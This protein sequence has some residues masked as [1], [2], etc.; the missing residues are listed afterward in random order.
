MSRSLSHHPMQLS[1]TV[2]VIVWSLL[3]APSFTFA[4][5]PDHP[6]I[7][8]NLLGDEVYGDFVLGP[9]KLEVTI[10]PGETKVVDITVSNRMGTPRMF[11][12]TAEDAVGSQDPTQTVVLL[13]ED[14][15]PYSMKDYVSVPTARFTLGHNERVRV[16]V[17][18]S[19]P[20]DAEPGGRY[21]SL[22][23][24]TVSQEAN[25]GVDAG[26]SP[27][28]AIVA[29]IG[30]LF[31]ITVPGETKKEGSLIQFGVVPERAIHQEGPL[32]F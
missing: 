32:T 7:I 26:T 14:R 2:L 1:F 19:I 15:G 20:Q 21:G 8:E 28:S 10:N 18:I 17:T 16:P 29:R 25:T 3:F 6:Y 22:L 31:F 9:G 5:T 27:Q 4:Q 24:S 11:E 23:V 12:V 30:S 13:G